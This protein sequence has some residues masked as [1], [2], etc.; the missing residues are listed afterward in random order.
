MIKFID[1]EIVVSAMLKK[2][3][4]EHGNLS[5]PVNFKTKDGYTFAGWFVKNIFAGEPIT[6]ITKGSTGDRT[7]YAKWEENE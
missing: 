7:L 3:R 2:F 6:E 1:E 5:I 4:Q